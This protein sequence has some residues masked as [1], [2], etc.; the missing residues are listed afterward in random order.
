M[1][2]NIDHGEIKLGQLLT[3][4]LS[5]AALALREPLLLVI[6]GIAFVLGGTVRWLS[7]FGAIYRWVVRPLGLMRSDYR[8]DNLQAHQFGQLVGVATA[9]AAWGLI[10]AG[11]PSAGWAVVVVLI[12]LTAISYFGW[13]IGC[14]LYYQLNRLGLRGFFGHAPTDRSVFPGRR[15][16]KGE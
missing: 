10:Q 12:A 8:L 1:A 6:L 4:A 11:Y 15:P 13:C 2:S 9:A 14:F 5:G 7:P 16:R 3:I